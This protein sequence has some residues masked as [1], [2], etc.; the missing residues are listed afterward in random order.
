MSEEISFAEGNFLSPEKSSR[1]AMPVW[2][3]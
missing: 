2:W 1:R 3:Y